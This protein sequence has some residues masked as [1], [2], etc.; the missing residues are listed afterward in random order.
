MITQSL[1]PEETIFISKIVYLCVC[2]GAWSKLAE[3]ERV[4]QGMVL[5]M[6]KLKLD[7]EKKDSALTV[8]CTQ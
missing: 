2:V 1:I 3:S 7:L 8:M 4:C 6:S 5:E